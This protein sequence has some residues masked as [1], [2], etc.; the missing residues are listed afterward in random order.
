ML[1]AG[2]FL[3]SPRAR[4]SLKSKET[5]QAQWRTP[6]VPALGSRGISKRRL[7]LVLVNHGYA[8]KAG[9][10]QLPLSTKEANGSTDAV[11]PS[12]EEAEAAELG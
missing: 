5:C 1:G 2:F 3:A 6:S 8:V 9:S 7:L 11:Y 4:R 10:D 12:A